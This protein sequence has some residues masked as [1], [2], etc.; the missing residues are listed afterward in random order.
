M[1]SPK[2]QRITNNN[3]QAAKCVR[4]KT[5]TWHQLWLTNLDGAAGG[6]GRQ[7]KINTRGLW[8]PPRLVLK[9]KMEDYYKIL[10]CDQQASSE[11]IKKQYKNLAL[12]VCCCC[13]VR[14]ANWPRCPLFLFQKHPDKSIGD[15]EKANAEFG[16]LNKAAKTLLD[17]KER[18]KYDASL[19]GELIFPHTFEVDNVL[20]KSNLIATNSSTMSWLWKSLHS[21]K[22]NIR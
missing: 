5:S 1:F 7:K 19:L 11:E 10:E 22:V 12:K 16:L 20:D 8:N 6:D 4:S 17:E 15:D 18:F 9:R 13:F 14:L 3:N 21:T 2:V